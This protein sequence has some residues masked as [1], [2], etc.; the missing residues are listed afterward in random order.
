MAT[1]R[2]IPS[3]IGQNIK[4]RRKVLHKSAKDFA[5]DIGITY[6]HL[7]QIETKGVNIS[8]HL[9]FKMAEVLSTQPDELIKSNLV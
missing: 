2:E 8:V 6:Q 7:W 4:N 5:S 9:L 1:N 3:Y